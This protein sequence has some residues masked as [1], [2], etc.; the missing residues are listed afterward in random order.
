MTTPPR[1]TAP[2][3]GAPGTQ[4]APARRLRWLLRLHRP[5][6]CVWTVLV[7]VLAALLLWLGGPLTDAS[8][9]AWNQYD[10][11]PT[12]GACGYDQEAILLYKDVSLYTSLTVLTLPFL[13]AMWAGASLIG[14][15]LE[16]GTAR[17]AWTQG[18]SPTRWLTAK[19]ALPAALVTVG[20]AL[21][22]LLNRLAWTAGLGRVDTAKPWYSIETF[23]ASGPVVVAVALAGLA[24]GT[25]LGLLLR[26][27][28]AALV[29]SVCATAALW[30]GIFMALPH[31]WPTV[32]RV[33][34]LREGPSGSGI[35]VAEGLLTADGD[36][37][38]IPRYCG[39]SIDP[40]C[41]ALFDRLDAV[42]F[43]RDYHPASHYWPLQFVASGILLAVAVLLTVLTFRVLRHRTADHRGGLA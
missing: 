41:G 14:R 22:A 9:A 7:V 26:R 17:L 43:Y 19:L 25:L 27:S 3:P 20:T 37:L 40:S 39:S 10:A 36:R 30:A 29:G 38:G 4:A 8:A 15:E 24:A 2:A 13:V 42:S 28:L 6:L 18:V 34:S 23:Y 11:C 35:G 31:L 21:A 12:T 16:S 32:T 33:S 1:A 5:A